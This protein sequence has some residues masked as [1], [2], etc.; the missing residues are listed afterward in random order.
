MM[1]DIRPLSLS[2]DTLAFCK[3]SVLNL[4]FKNSSVSSISSLCVVEHIGLGRYADPLDPYGS[5][6]AIE[7]LKR[8]LKRGG[9]LYVS[10]PIHDKNR[11]YFN[12]H[13]AFEEKYLLQLFRYFDIMDRRYI[14]GNNFSMER[15][16][17]F[18][19]ACYHLRRS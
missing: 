6:K 3:G 5:E 16:R 14:Y 15:K 10:L 1:V 13:R 9:D 4:P 2:L 7:E 12:A 17:G 18:H 19:I 8:V 11:V